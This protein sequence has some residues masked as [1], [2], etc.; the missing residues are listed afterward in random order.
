VFET[1][2]GYDRGPNPELSIAGCIA[3]AQLRHAAPPDPSV[4]PEVLTITGTSLRNQS[5]WIAVPVEQS[6]PGLSRFRERSQIEFHLEESDTWLVA[7]LPALE[8]IAD[9]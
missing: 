5:A 2:C 7:E 9:K 8:G 1:Y 6:D 4:V 3:P